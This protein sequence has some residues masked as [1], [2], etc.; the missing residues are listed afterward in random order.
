MINPMFVRVPPAIVR[1]LYEHADSHVLSSHT[2]QV[3]PQGPDKGNTF[4]L[5]APSH[6]GDVPMTNITITL[7]EGHH[8]EAIDLSFIEDKD[9]RPG[10]ASFKCRRNALEQGHAKA[11][12]V[13]WKCVGIA[14]TRETPKPHATLFCHERLA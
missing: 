5:V 1:P 12:V 10:H 8:R 4:Y 6:R 14:L 2:R 3:D 7:E 11:F 9:C 13:G